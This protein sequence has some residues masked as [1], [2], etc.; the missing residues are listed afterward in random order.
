MS[1]VFKLKTKKQKRPYEKD[2]QKQKASDQ[3]RTNNA[4]EFISI[5][6]SS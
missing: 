6:K 3:Q 2:K 1:S 5:V 4:T